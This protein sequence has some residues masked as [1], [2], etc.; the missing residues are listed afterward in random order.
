MV[1]QSLFQLY[2]IGTL[3]AF[4]AGLM[5]MGISYRKEYCVSNRI[6]YLLIFLF[7]IFLLLG[8]M[9]K[10]YAIKN[11]ADFAVWMEIVNNISRGLG[12]WSSIQEGIYPGTGHFFSAH[13][14]PLV[15]LFAIPFKIFPARETL[16]LSQF[17]LLLSAIPA[18]YLYAKWW[19]KDSNQALA[20]A[21]VFSIYPTYQYIHLYEF[22][23]LRFSI[24]I[25]L[26]LFYA[27][28]RE[29]FKTYWFLLALVLLV[30]EE[31]AVTTFMF[32]I[33]ILLFARDRF[34]IGVA[35][36]LVSITYFLF[37]MKILMPYFRSATD[38][39][40][41]AMI[42]FADLGGS[43]SEVLIGIVTR[44]MVVIGLLA[45]P[46]KVANLFMYFLPLLFVPFVSWP[47]VLIASGNIGINLLS[48][49]MTHTTYLLYYLSPSIPFL[50]VALIKGIPILGGWL[51][52]I[53]G[54]SKNLPKGRWAVICGVLASVFVANIFF[55]PSPASL[56][57]W[58]KDFRVGP[59][60]TLNFHYSQYIF[61]KRDRNLI[62]VLRYV[63]LD[64]SVSVM[65]HILPLV[66]DRKV[67]KIFPDITGVNYVVFDKFRKVAGVGTVEGSWNGLRENPQRYFD[68]VEKAP[69]QWV[70]VTKQDGYFVY[71]RKSSTR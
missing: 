65:Q 44:P 22:E 47:V 6:L 63:P 59:F 13:F 68:W 66:F 23:M 38:S 48:S 58:F 25:L 60:R 21:A 41:F 9:L 51:N 2:L 55:G 31:I 14:T 52:T 36:C 57:F 30:R 17:V 1:S 12:P 16:I 20:L 39:T 54:N 26:F 15:Y 49:S 37:V 28:E 67:L 34:R 4:A 18:V 5:A 32:G 42:L 64:A 62:N 35:T 46:V 45:D 71:R 7:P 70:L 19:L 53:G 11:Y 29:F 40:H 56:Q 27:F 3:T 50:F 61:T 8:A 10:L 24:P 69:N 33:Y 43:I